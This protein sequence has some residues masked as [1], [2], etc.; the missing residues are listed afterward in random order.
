MATFDVRHFTHDDAAETR[1]TLD[2]HADAYADRADDPF[3][4]RF[5]WFLDH[6]S[7]HSGSSCVI[8]YDGSE[9]IGWCCD[10]IGS[11]GRGS[12]RAWMRRDVQSAPR[13]GSASSLEGAESWPFPLIARRPWRR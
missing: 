3:V 9:P 5:P 12:A 8:G 1:Q 10:R 4:Q 7:S 13:D 2:L 6:W 11:P